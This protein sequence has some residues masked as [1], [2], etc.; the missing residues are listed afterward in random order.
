MGAK[1]V[2]RIFFAANRWA[3]ILMLAAMSVLIFANV[4]MRYLTRES[5]VWAE[6]VARHLMIWMTFI[7]A[8]PVLRAGGHIAIENLQDNLPR[9]MA[10]LLRVVVALL[11]YAFFIFMIW[12]GIEYMERTQYQ[13]TAATQIS[14]AWVYA[15][16]PIG[17]V[18]LIIHWTLIIRDYLLERRFAGEDGFDATASASL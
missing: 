13:L 9:P 10:I 17:G 2:E 18:L 8:G 1:R 11:L 16:M 4:L 12:Y 15:A 7:G 3:L 5:I 6:E 14:F